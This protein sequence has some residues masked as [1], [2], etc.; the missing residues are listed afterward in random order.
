[1]HPQYM[2]FLLYVIVIWYNGIAEMYCH[3]EWGLMYPQYMCF[4]L[5]V[6][7]ILCNGV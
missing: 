3:L 4:L 2:C 1:M 7:V 5:Y 6:T